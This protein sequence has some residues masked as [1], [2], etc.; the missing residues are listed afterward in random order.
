MNGL[1]KELEIALEEEDKAIREW[2]V[3]NK[4]KVT[5]GMHDIE[6]TPPEFFCP[7]CFKLRKDWIGRLRQEGWTDEMFEQAGWR[8]YKDD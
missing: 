1:R 7:E 6:L 2:L 3:K 5:C 8:N 4:A